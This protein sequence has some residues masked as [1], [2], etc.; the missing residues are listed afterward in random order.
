MTPGELPLGLLSALLFTLMG[1]I[2]LMPLFAGAT[3][4][5]EPALRR[6]VALLAAA[7]ATGALALAVLIGANVMAAWGVTPPAL[8]MT[9]GIVLLATALRNLLGLTSPPPPPGPVTLWTALT[10]IAVPG[11]ATPVAVAVL[12]IFASYFPGQASTLA[13]LGAVLS[14]MTINLIAMLFAHV[15]MAKVGPAP[16]IVLG[17]V[18][19]VLQAALGLQFILNGLLLT[20]LFKG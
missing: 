20:P 1:P 3:A 12:I 4:G 18:F 14:I 16:L 19:G 13:L 17:A 7:I 8:V 10:P 15:F 6:K 2:A 9:A 11:T 5:A